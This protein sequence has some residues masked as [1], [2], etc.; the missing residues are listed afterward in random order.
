[1]LEEAAQPLTD[2]EIARVASRGALSYV[3]RTG[4]SLLLQTVGSLLIARYLDPRNYGLFGLGLTITGALRYVGDL[5]VTFRFTVAHRL[6]D[7]DFRRGLALGLMTAL[8]GALLLA[9]L[10]QVLPSVA[11]A[12]SNVRLLG[13]AFGLYLL[14]T[15]PI[16]P[17]T[18]LLERR[19]EFRVV[20]TIGVVGALA[21]S[22]CLISLLLIGLGVWALILGQI[23]G[24]AVALALATRA[25]GGFPRPTLRGPVIALVRAS[26]PYQAPLMAQAVVGTAFPLI[27]V[28]ILGTRDLGFVT[29]ST[30]LATPFLSLIFALQPVIAPSLA[31][32]LRDDGSRY[33]DASM[34]VLMTLVVLSA[35]GAGAVIGLVPP[36]VRFVFAARWLPAKEAVELCLLGIIP[37]SLVVGCASIVSSRNQP[38]KTVRASL[39]GGA[40]A[41]AVTVPAALLAGVPGAAAAVYVVAPLIELSVLAWLGDIRLGAVALRGA[42]LLLPLG[43]AS[44]EVGRR[45]NSPVA[46]VEGAAV[47]GVAAIL[48]L[49]LFERQLIRSLWRRVR[50]Q[51]G[52]PSWPSAALA[53]TSIRRLV[54]LLAV[55]LGLSGVAVALVTDAH[56]GTATALIVA[57]VA[58]VALWLFFNPRPETQPRAAPH[59]PRSARRV[60]QA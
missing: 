5:G 25:V 19:L 22:A 8:A 58:L 14:V 13:P 29:W 12:S 31:R 53:T 45:V 38:G 3:T 46:L 17:L 36:I 37:S 57:L 21:G 15:A 27:V 60:H 1:M 39:V 26:L 51:A 30:I 56:V 11:S 49:S 28:S 4:L 7:D 47:M 48:L 9:G 18:A 34:T 16:G 55:E 52:A 2:L 41:V 40:T 42:R 24:S 32:M 50:P 6:S 10:W 54:G 44:L 59:L 23:A 43:V 20:G 35:A 33:A